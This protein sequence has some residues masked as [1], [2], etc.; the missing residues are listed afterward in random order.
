[1]GVINR[2]NAIAGWA[3]WKLGKRILRR[4]AA[5]APQQ[6]ASVARRPRALVAFLVAAGAGVASFLRAR[7]GGGAE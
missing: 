1:M 3:V 2:R 6:V 5:R 4:K 7:K